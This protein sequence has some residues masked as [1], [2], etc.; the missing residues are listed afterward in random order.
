MLNLILHTN[1]HK[2]QNSS[3]KNSLPN[4]R[5]T[6]IYQKPFN[7]FAP[8]LNWSH[9]RNSGNQNFPNNPFSNPQNQYLARPTQFTRP[10]PFKQ[11][12]TQQSQNYFRPQFRP[13]FPN[14]MPQ[15]RPNTFAPGNRSNHYRPTPMDTSS[16]NISRFQRQQ[17]RQPTPKLNQ[18][19]NF[20]FEELYYQQA[21]PEFFD[22]DQNYS[23]EFDYQAY[24]D[25]RVTDEQQNYPEITYPEQNLESDNVQNFHM[26]PDQD[27]PT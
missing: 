10:L 16:G 7:S 17:Q 6:P 11:N 23:T 8:P 13:Q 9:V 27:N 15:N 12:F 14:Q 25:S 20:V 24:D 1:A 26:D 21:E 18:R 4:P 5:L 2:N 22:Y 3:H 19:P